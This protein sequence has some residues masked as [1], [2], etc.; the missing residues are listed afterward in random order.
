M[1]RVMGATISTTGKAVAQMMA[2]LPI[3]AWTKCAPN[4]KARKVDK[5]E[6]R[7]R[8][9]NDFGFAGIAA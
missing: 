4:P 5:P 3:Q 7:E 8:L 9:I 6:T 1:R 2:Q